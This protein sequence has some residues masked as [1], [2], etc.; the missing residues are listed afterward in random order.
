MPDPIEQDRSQCRCGCEAGA[1]YCD[2]CA[3]LVFS[4]VGPISDCPGCEIYS[5]PH[6]HVET[7]ELSLLC[8]CVDV[9]CGCELGGGDDPCRLATYAL[10]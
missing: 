2:E 4:P 5:R 1:G 3:T 6:R 10:G 8:D 9:P 7:Y